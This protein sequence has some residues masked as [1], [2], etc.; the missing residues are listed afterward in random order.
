MR[1]LGIDYGK[2][3]VGVALSDEGGVMAFPYTVLPNSR[4]LA[5]RV[6]ALCKE[7][8]VDAVVVGLSQTST[9]VDNPITKDVDRFV[10]TL[11]E[12]T[13]LPFHLEPEFYSTQEALRVQGRTGHT[14]ASAAAIIL[15]RFLDKENAPDPS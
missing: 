13:E 5:D 7:K 6:S 3:R 2:K 8:A 9:G 11:T 4:S 10:N 12:R 1:F 15:Q 14:D